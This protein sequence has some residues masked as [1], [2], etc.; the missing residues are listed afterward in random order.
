MFIKRF[1]RENSVYASYF[2]TYTHFR[3][4]VFFLFVFSNSKKQRKQ[5]QQEAN[6]ERKAA[7]IELLIPSVSMA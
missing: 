3:Q 2:R 5:N 4:L 1:S 7:K 6:K